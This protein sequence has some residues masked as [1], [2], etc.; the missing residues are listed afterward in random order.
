L[1]SRASIKLGCAI[2]SQ[3]VV[4]EKQ[5]TDFLRLYE[6][7][8]QKKMSKCALY[9]LGQRQ[10]TKAQL[11][12]FKKLLTSDNI[13]LRTLSALTVAQN[14]RFKLA[15]KYDIVFTRFH[16]Y[17]KKFVWDAFCNHVVF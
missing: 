10:T 14:E 16:I 1:K 7:E 9:T 2:D 13:I 15:R 8:W 11:L 6:L 12:P 3:D 17:I 4:A 5:A